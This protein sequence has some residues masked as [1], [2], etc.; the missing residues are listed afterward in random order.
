MSIHVYPTCPSSIFLRV[1]MPWLSDV[2]CYFAVWTAF[3][4]RYSSLFTL[5]TWTF[6]CLDSPKDSEITLS[7]MSWPVRTPYSCDMMEHC[8]LHRFATNCNLV[9]HFRLALHDFTGLE[10]L[11]LQSSLCHHMSPQ[12]LICRFKMFQ[13]GH[14]RPWHHMASENPGNFCENPCS[15]W[16]EQ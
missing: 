10:N 2:L 11:R 9:I 5:W 6:F 3:C 7:Y 12:P 15:T 1:A 8:N 13:F 4:R 14:M 16:L